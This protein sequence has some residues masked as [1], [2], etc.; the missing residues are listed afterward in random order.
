MD[1][2][3]NEHIQ[4]YEAIENKDLPTARKVLSSHIANVKKHA[5]ESTRR[6]LQDKRIKP[7]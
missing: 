6:A 7:M 5:I 3:D 4:L 2:V 1:R